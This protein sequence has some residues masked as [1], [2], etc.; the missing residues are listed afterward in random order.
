LGGAA[1]REATDH[2]IKSGKDILQF[3]GI[4]LLATMPYKETVEERRQRRFKRLAF[5]MGCI[6]IAG[7]ILLVINSLVLPLSDVFSFVFERLAY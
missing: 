6:G 1:F 3:E 4:D 5:S 2:T 7:L